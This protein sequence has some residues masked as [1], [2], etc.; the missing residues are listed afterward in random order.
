MY[1]TRPG[2]LI[3]FHGCDKSRQ[4]HL[5]QGPAIIPLSKEPFDWL[6][7]GMY[8]WENNYDRALQWAESKKSKGRIDEAAVIG[9][10]LDLSYCCDL[11]DSKFISMLARYYRL[12]EIEYSALKKEIPSNKDYPCDPHGDKLMRFRDCAT[13]EFMHKKIR[14]QVRMDLISKGYTGY[15]IFDSVRGM[16][17][18]GGPAYEG[19]GFHVKS[20][21]Q[22]CIRNS[23]CIKG[24]FIKREE[25]DFVKKETEPK[26]FEYRIEQ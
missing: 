16:F 3:G 1:N 22:M 13:I 5:L 4:Q 21:I 9:A 11:L 17:S 12:L 18:E 15:K 23:N 24:F 19:A 20:H 7:H 6:G 14:E 10:V 8:F 25:I 26:T 2:L